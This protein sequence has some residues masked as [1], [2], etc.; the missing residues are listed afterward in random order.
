MVAYASLGGR[1]FQNFPRGAV[2]VPGEIPEHMNP[3]GGL[4]EMHRGAVAAPG[5]GLVG[6]TRGEAT[7]S[8]P[9]ESSQD[10]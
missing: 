7:R 6:G 1:E 10:I 3:L 2:A 4:P 5:D 9:C 8:P